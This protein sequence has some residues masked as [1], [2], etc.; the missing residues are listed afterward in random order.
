M[1]GFRLV[2]N[3]KNFNIHNPMAIFTSS[4]VNIIAIRALL[5]DGKTMAIPKEKKSLLYLKKQPRK[6]KCLPVS[7]MAGKPAAEVEWLE[8]DLCEGVAARMGLQLAG[9]RLQ[10]GESIPKNIKIIR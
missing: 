7:G 5:N 8:D 10:S 9:G 1:L 6:S 4:L 3:T 2:G